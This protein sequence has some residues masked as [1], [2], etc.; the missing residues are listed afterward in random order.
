[1]F[2]SS[3]NDIY[4]FVFLQLWYLCLGDCGN[5]LR[6]LRNDMRVT[7]FNVVILNI[8]LPH[9]YF[10]IEQG[11]KIVSFFPPNSQV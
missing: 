11:N 7:L 10:I 4:I 8:F 1:M 5:V 6:N 9:A 2:L 3:L